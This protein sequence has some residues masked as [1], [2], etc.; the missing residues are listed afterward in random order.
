[1]RNVSHESRP[2][3]FTK[4]S[5][6]IWVVANHWKKTLLFKKLFSSTTVFELIFEKI[7]KIP[8]IAVY[9]HVGDFFLCVFFCFLL[10]SKCQHLIVFAQVFMCNFPNTAFCCF[11]IFSQAIFAK[12]QKKNIFICLFLY[13]IKDVSANVLC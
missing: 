5:F 11:N 2:T 4:I 3:H 8:P 7:F 10:I 13:R 12:M 9:L 1:M 6:N